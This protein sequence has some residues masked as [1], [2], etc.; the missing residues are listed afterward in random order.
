MCMR[1]VD[2]TELMELM[3]CLWLENVLLCCEGGDEIWDS[4]LLVYERALV[5][6]VGVSGGVGGRSVGAGGCCEVW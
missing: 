1:V 4:G 6:R 2:V 5:C 3:E